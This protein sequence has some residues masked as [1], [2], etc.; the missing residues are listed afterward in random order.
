MHKGPTQTKGGKMHE[1]YIREYDSNGVRQLQHRLIMERHLGRKLVRGETVHHK[2]GDG[3]NNAIENLELWYR[4]QP[5]GQRVSDLLEY[6]VRFHA[7]KIAVLL[8]R[9]ADHFSIKSE[10]TSPS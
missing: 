4:P 8:N 6:A 2:W 1:R 9:V 10:I 3:K 7:E 5:A